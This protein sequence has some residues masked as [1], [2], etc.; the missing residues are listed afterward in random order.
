MTFYKLVSLNISNNF[1][2]ICCLI[3]NI[4]GDIKHSLGFPGGTNG[5][6]LTCQCRK[7][8]SHVL[9][10]CQEDPLEKEMAIHSNILVWII[11][12]I[13]EPRGLQSMG[14]QRLRHDWSNWACMQA[15]SLTFSKYLYLFINL[16]FIYFYLV[17]DVL[18]FSK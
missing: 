5:R 14:S 1:K 15:F 9:D 13:E 18:I 12:W 2:I 6:N 17:I 10:P 8:K 7:R 3:E 16:L 11:P 4:L